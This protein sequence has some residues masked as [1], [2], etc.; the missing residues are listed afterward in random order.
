MKRASKLGYAIAF[1]GISI[2]HLKKVLETECFLGDAEAE[3]LREIV[4]NYNDIKEF[5][6]KEE[7]NEALNAISNAITD[8]KHHEITVAFSKVTEDGIH[9]TGHSSCEFDMNLAYGLC[10]KLLY[11][12]RTSG[13]FEQILLELIK[14]VNDRV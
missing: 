12:L 13:Q 1:L 10:K 14:E 11:D 9:V 6:E 8:P 3:I 7:F 4:V 2:D 5:Y